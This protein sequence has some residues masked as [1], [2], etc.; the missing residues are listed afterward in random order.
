MA[1]SDSSQSGILIFKNYVTV[2][3]LTDKLVATNY[4][5]W[6]SNIKQWL[7]LQHYD[8]HL[9]NNIESVAESDRGLWKMIDA[10]ICIILKS[11][12]DSSLENF[13]ITLITCESV[14]KKAKIFDITDARR[15]YEL[16][17]NL[18]NV[19]SPGR[20]D[21]SM[22]D[23]L[24]KIKGFLHDFNEILPPPGSPEEA[25]EQQETFF[26]MLALYGLPM[27]YSMVRNQ[28]LDSSVLPTWN[29][30]SA[31]LLRV[32]VAK[33]SLNV[34]GTD[35]HCGRSRRHGKPRPKCDHCHKLGHTIDRCFALHG[36]P[37]RITSIAP[38]AQRK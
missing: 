12:I 8:D 1:G 32:V 2:P 33:P 30:V 21:G 18:M 15:L 5:T 25:F 37:T 11:T 19:V 17:K 36:R 6:S 14:W 34:D 3:L 7:R 29:S 35:A 26:I 9:T 23:Y 16:W 31:T 38:T 28:I 13:F 10:Q 24:D 22:A 4:H 27:E 20:I